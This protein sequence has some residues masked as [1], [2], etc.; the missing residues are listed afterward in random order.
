M[1]PVYPQEALGTGLFGT[2]TLKVTLDQFGYVGEARATEL[3]FSGGQASAVLQ[4]AFRKSAVD[5]VKQW[6]YDAPASPP[7]SLFVQVSF[8]PMPK[9]ASCGTTPSRRRRA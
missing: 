7:I 4:G 5:A 3:N 8:V 1:A 9:A 6:I 2:L